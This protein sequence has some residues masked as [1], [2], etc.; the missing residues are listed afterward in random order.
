MPYVIGL[1]IITII[2]VGFTLLQNRTD[3]E[4]ITSEQATEIARTTDEEP[5]V[6]ETEASS[7]YINGSYTTEVFYLTPARDEYQMD[8]TVTLQNDIVI[9]STIV[10]SRGAEV[11]PNPQ[12]FNKAYKAEIIGKNIDEINLSRVGGA[13]LTSTAFNEGL[14]LIKEQAS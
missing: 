5:A 13:S 7:T 11:D 6:M 12:R 4:M 8:I 2:G 3:E 14:D 1:L 9:D 10:Y